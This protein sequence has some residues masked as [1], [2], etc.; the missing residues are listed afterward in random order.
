[1]LNGN[2]PPPPP[3]PPRQNN[4]HIRFQIELNKMI[5]NYNDNCVNALFLTILIR[6]QTKSQRFIKV[7]VSK[8]TTCDHLPR[9]AQSLFTKDFNC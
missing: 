3:P 7:I 6:S 8:L 5:I 4:M 9:V 2:P 1:M